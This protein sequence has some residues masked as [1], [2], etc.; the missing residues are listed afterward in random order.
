MTHTAVH[1]HYRKLFSDKYDAYD[2]LG[3]AAVVRGKQRIMMA[4]SRIP[5]DCAHH[6]AHNWGNDAAR[7]ELDRNEHLTSYIFRRRSRELA[8]IQHQEHI[9]EG[10]V[11]A[12]LWC[13][14]CQ[15]R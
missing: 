9:A 11:G 3:R 2:K 5:Y 12:Y 1:E 4:D 8:I 6:L 13:D 7:Q 10:R 15:G 14:A